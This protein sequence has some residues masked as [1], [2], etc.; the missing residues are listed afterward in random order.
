LP[1]TAAQYLQI[2]RASDS[3]HEFYRG[4]MTA[5]TGASYQHTLIVRNLVIDLGNRLRGGPCRAIPNDLRVHSDRIGFY[6]YPDLVIHCGEPQFLDGHFD[7]LTNPI[8]LIEVLSDSTE[9][10]DRG[11]KFDR[12]QR[13]DTLRTYVLV[14]QRNM[15]VWWYDRNEPG[16]PA[17]WTLHTA[18]LPT[19]SLV[20]DQ[21]GTP[22]SIP[23]ADIYADVEFD[24]IPDA[25]PTGNQP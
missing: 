12:Y 16:H 8:A 7:T 24:P 20:L 6:T 10:Y 21:L 14:S 23:L 5:M 18:S 19:E 11:A 13:L 22:V 2:E 9:A 4:E 17:T 15:S 25:P 1:L 3:R